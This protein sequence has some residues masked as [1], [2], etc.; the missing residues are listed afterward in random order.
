[1]IPV[2]RIFL[3]AGP[4]GLLTSPTGRPRADRCRQWARDLLAAGARVV[5]PEVAD[6]EI[7]RELIRIGATAGIR[8]LDQ[9]KAGLE[10]API[11]T[12][13]ML[14]A[15]E[16]WA[17]TRRAGRPTA[18]PDALD[19]DCILAAQATLAAGPGDTVTVATT[20]V[21]HLGRFVDAR[22]WESIAP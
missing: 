20:N 12:A 8:R 21:A 4:L 15:A 1:M 7:R 6:N 17:D 10:Y 5:V 16:Y 13:A 11:T 19:G 18:S 2:R 9:A 14:L 3:D 22:T